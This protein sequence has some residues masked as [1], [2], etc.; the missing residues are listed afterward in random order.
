[1]KTTENTNHAMTSNKLILVFRPYLISYGMSIILLLFICQ[2]LFSQNSST[3][4]DDFNK[5]CCKRSFVLAHEEPVAFTYL[6]QA[7]NMITYKTPDGKEA[8]AYEIKASGESNKYLLV[9]H[10]WYGLNDY[11]KK[12]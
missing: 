8:N 10:E 12:E 11:I 4:P 9:F 1:M 6:N 7:G 5:L 3:A 2:N